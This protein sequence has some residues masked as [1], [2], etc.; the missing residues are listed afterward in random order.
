MT[1]NHRYRV[2]VKEERGKKSDE[3]D[4]SNY[5]NDRRRLACQIAHYHRIG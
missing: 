2:Q 4:T 5:F 3:A 1:A